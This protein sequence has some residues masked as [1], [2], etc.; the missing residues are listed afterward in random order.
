M[1][2]FTVGDD[3]EVF[4]GP[5]E[6]GVVRK[7]YCYWYVHEGTFVIPDANAT[8]GDCGDPMSIR[9]VPFGPS[10]GCWMNRWVWRLAIRESR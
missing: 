6:T 9:P 2:D 3:E 4:V 1:Q 7:N 5:E 8:L 10:R